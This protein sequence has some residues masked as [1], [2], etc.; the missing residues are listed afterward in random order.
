MTEDRKKG[1]ARVSEIYQDRAQRARELKA[2]GKKVARRS[3]GK[4]A[5]KDPLNA[6]VIDKIKVFL[7]EKEVCFETKL[8]W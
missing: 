1:L 4:I 6:E 5:K 7:N 3:W 8:P 2:E